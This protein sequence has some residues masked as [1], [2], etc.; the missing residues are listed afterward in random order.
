MCV[1]YVYADQEKSNQLLS[2][3]LGK[4]YVHYYFFKK[5]LMLV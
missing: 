3:M 5:K 1:V 2:G 4:K